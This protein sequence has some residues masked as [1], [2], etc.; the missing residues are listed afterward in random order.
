MKLEIQLQL[1]L[2]MTETYNKSHSKNKILLM[3]S[4]WGDENNSC[5]EIIEIGQNDYY[6][7]NTAAS[8]WTLLSI[9]GQS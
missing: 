3:K 2:D 7:V 1:L 9:L 6:T 5:S 8:D 4:M